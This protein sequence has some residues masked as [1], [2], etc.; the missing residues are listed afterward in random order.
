M[1]IY[2]VVFTVLLQVLIELVALLGETWS[3]VL[4]NVGEKIVEMGKFCLLSRSEL[5]E[6][7]LTC[8]NNLNR[9]ARYRYYVGSI[10]HYFHGLYEQT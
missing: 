9:I 2:W 5:G 10:T 3:Q 7:L 1:F 8:L 6:H 4:V